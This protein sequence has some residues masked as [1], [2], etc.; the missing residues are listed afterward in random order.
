MI[1]S[2]ITANYHPMPVASC[3]VSS[4]HAECRVCLSVVVTIDPMDVP[5]PVASE[6]Q[7]VQH[8]IVL[9]LFVKEQHLS[10]NTNLKLCIG[11]Y[12]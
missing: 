11:F 2:A 1:C 10:P 8:A 7:E 5:T 12:S 4:P 9:H 6:H 3:P